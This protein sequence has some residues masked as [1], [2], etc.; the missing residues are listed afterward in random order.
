MDGVVGDFRDCCRSLSSTRRQQ[1]IL[2]DLNSL[3]S[4]P[5]KG[6]RWPIFAGTRP[7]NVWCKEKYIKKPE[8]SDLVGSGP[9][10]KK[11][12]LV[13]LCGPD[14]IKL[15]ELC[16][17][18]FCPGKFDK[19]LPK[20][21]LS[22]PTFGHSVGSTKLDRP[23][24]KQF[25]TLR[26]PKQI[27]LQNTSSKIGK[28]HVSWFCEWQL[29]RARGGGDKTYRKAKPREDSPSE[30]AFWDP[31]R[32]I[33]YMG[34]KGLICH[35]PR[36]LP[37]SIWGLT[38]RSVTMTLFNLFF[39][40][41]K[42]KMTNRPCFTP[43]PREILGISK[44]LTKRNGTRGY[45][46]EGG[47]EAVFR[48]G[49]PREVLRPPPFSPPPLAFSGTRQSVLSAYFVFSN[50]WLEKAQGLA[51]Q[52]EGLL[53]TQ[54]AH[55]GGDFV[56]QKLCALAEKLLATCPFLQAGKPMKSTEIIGVPKSEFF[57]CAFGPVSSHPFTLTFP[58][59][60]PFKPCSLS[61]HFPPLA[62]V[63]NPFKP[64][65]FPLQSGG[66]GF[67]T[68][69]FVAWG[70][71]ITPSKLITFKIRGCGPCRLRG[72]HTICRVLYQAQAQWTWPYS[73]YY[74][75]FIHYRRINS[76]S[77]EISCEFSPGNKVFQRPCR[78]VLLLSY[79]SATTVVNSYGQLESVT[80]CE[81][82]WPAPNRSDIWPTPHHVMP[83]TL[84]IKG[85]GRHVMWKLR[86]KICIS[87]HYFQ[88]QKIATRD[89]FHQLII[90][91]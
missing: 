69:C 19:M 20:P 16:V 10:P 44:G 43:P 54:C 84:V 35:F 4:M 27:V 62:P 3:V 42:N 90:W 83:K 2:Y 28:R 18:L 6:C 71:K 40:A 29:C 89:G 56:F 66:S 30:T 8:T 45:R 81:K 24:C 76:L 79:F 77:M 52:K 70:S 85:R 14:W 22:K 51:H 80:W 87:K 68:S 12:N 57:E 47:L 46:G 37:A 58:P 67:Q 55:F 60:F 59:S 7:C 11:S 86:P 48:G 82:S 26:G 5:S 88:P 75:V 31:P 38:K 78:S 63:W 34:K 61:H 64:D 53:K 33:V 21:R 39:Q 32:E 9:S 15:S 50:S 49:S 25:R 73:K 91:P 41:W 13:N 65:C 23:Y 17:L 72:L 74:D 36:A 1:H